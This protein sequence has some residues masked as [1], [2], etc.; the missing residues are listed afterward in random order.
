MRLN[1][2]TNPDRTVTRLL[3]VVL[4]VTAA[5]VVLVS[6]VLVNT[7][8]T[9]GMIC[10][11]VMV[12]GFEIALLAAWLVL[13]QSGSYG[14]LLLALLIV[15]GIVVVPA[16]LAN[17]TMLTDDFLCVLASG[18]AAIIGVVITG[19]VLK[20]L[21]IASVLPFVAIVAS[22][23]VISLAVALAC[24]GDSTHLDDVFVAGG[25]AFCLSI[26]VAVVLYVLYCLSTSWLR[27][28]L[29]ERIVISQIA[30]VV[31]QNWP[32]ATGVALAAEAERGWARVHLR[33]IAALLGQGS[34]LSEAVRVGFPDCPS[35]PLGLMMAGEKAGR[36]AAAMDEAENYLFERERR[37]PADDVSIWTYALIVIGFATLVVAGIMVAIVPKY[38]EIFKDFSTKLPSATQSLIDVAEAFVNGT[39]PLWI[40][41]AI[42]VPLAVYW[43]LRPRRFPM[44]AWSSRVADWVR[45]RTPGWRQVEKARGLHAVLQV[46]RLGVQSGMNLAAAVR[47]AET[48]DVNAQLRPSVAKFGEL[49]ERGVSIRDAARH[50]GLG[51]VTGV[52]LAGGQRSGDMSA[53]LRY[54][55]DYYGSLAS[56]SWI[57]LRNMAWPVMTLMMGLVVGWVVVALFVPLVALINSV[58]G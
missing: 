42:V 53:A 55:V 58:T 52:T 37:K 20:R 47:L 4:I 36:L 13:K 16:I 14:R 24:V 38:K 17:T 48:I 6:S 31:R 34:P 46:T 7:E 32:L 23:I 29:T 27:R 56:R 2:N 51:E 21:N 50:A 40:V 15:L 35:I 11:A 30:T 54:V 45:W 12:G 10:A 28:R 43:S 26:G 41:P 19:F 8:T 5:V 22:A 1:P 33:R 57:V 39:P 3:P 44:L 25:I 9:V 49:L 18:G